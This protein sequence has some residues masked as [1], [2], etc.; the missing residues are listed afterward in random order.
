MS[1]NPGGDEPASWV[2]TVGPSHVVR[3]WRFP[4]YIHHH[5]I[6]YLE[7]SMILVEKLLAHINAFWLL[8]RP[9]KIKVEPNNGGLEE[10]FP[11]QLGY[12]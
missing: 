9:W 7:G 12:F 2:G 6:A 1:D 4:P 3:S 11:F 10:E 8:L 5:N